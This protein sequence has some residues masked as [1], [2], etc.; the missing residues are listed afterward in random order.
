MTHLIQAQ[1]LAKTYGKFQALKPS[2]FAIPAGQIVGLIG[3]NGAGKSTL[4]NALL[5]LQS[6]DG[7][8]TVLGRDPYRDRAALMAEVC[9]IADVA[10]LPK[11]LKVR[12]LLDLVA[13]LHPG[14][15]RAKAESRLAGTD[16]KLD[17]KVRALSKGMTVQLH[18]AIVLAIEAKL[19]V[20]DE[21]TLGLDLLNRRKFYDAILSDYFTPERS[22]LVTTHQVEEIEHVLTHVMMIRHGQIIVHTSVDELAERFA[23]VDVPSEKLAAGEAMTPLWKRQS[24]GRTTMLFDLQK[25]GAS[26]DAVAKLGETRRVPLADL[27]VALMQD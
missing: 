20:L 7:A 22:I 10:T 5:G 13:G 21:P 3:P 9:F 4:V 6:Y 27:F 15:D 18:L 19:L 11:W 23:V 1:G 17:A 14:F 8:L 16:V 2:S 25:G 26:A 24:F 12:E